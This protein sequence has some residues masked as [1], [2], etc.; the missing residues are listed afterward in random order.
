MTNLDELEQLAK[1]AITSGLPGD[2]MMFALKAMDPEG[3][4]ALIAEVRALRAGFSDDDIKR[5]LVAWF[6]PH[7]PDQGDFAAR[8]RKA[9]DA[10]KEKG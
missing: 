9:M 8:M 1:A 6:D 7:H 4:L 5:A 3:M 2:R 10:A